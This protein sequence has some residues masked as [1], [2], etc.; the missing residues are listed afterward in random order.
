MTNLKKKRIGKFSRTVVFAFAATSFTVGTSHAEET[1]WYVSAFAGFAIP[2]G[3]VDYTNGSTTVNTEFDTGFTFGGAVGYSWNDVDLGGIVPRTELEFNYSENNVDRL[4][5]SG[6]GAGD[7]VVFEGSQ[8]STVS[9]IG[10]LYLDA[11]DL[12]GHGITPYIGGGAGVA[13]TNHD[14]FYNVGLNLADDG[15][16]NFTWHVTGGVKYALNDSV[17]LF[18]D[19]GFRQIVNASSVRRLDA[20]PLA[21][22][23]GGVFED[24]IN[25]LYVRTGLSVGF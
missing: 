14:I 15:D 5:F 21:G 8:A 2:T 1:D 22:A 4:D 9:I 17:S 19:V 10:S 16:T 20:V 3:D 12:I 7:E 25:S 6:N 18:T 24:D 13:I 23:G 11:P